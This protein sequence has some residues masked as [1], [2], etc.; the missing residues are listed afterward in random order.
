MVRMHSNGRA[1]VG[2]M[3]LAITVVEVPVPCLGYSTINNITVMTMS[4]IAT[5]MV[6]LATYRYERAEHR[7]LG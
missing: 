7:I 6:L 1:M 4:A 3:K 5:H 2:E